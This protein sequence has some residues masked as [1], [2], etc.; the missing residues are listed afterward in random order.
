M[1]TAVWRSAGQAF[2]G[3]SL[4]SR[5]SDF[6]ASDGTGVRD[7]EEAAKAGSPSQRFPSTWLSSW[8]PV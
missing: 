3:L 7:F 4:N 5:S 8:M 6:S 1:T 2:Y